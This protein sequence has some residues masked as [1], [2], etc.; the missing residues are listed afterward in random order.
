M[1]VGTHGCGG[2]G[3]AIRRNCLNKCVGGRFRI[4]KA[5]VGCVLFFPSFFHASRL[6]LASKKNLRGGNQLAP[7]PIVMSWHAVT[8]M[9]RWKERAEKKNDTEKGLATFR[10]DG[11]TVTN[12]T[13]ASV[14]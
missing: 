7:L 13:R 1:Y 2:R 5:S 9:G 6:A 11:L 12:Q 10:P 3:A 14:D 8:G 4:F